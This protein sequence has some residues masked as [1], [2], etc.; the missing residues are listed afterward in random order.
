MDETVE[1]VDVG[2]PKK[3]WK[4]KKK[5]RTASECISRICAIWPEL[6]P[7]GDNLEFRPVALGTSQE[8]HDWVNANLEGRLSH[9]DI[10]RAMSF[11]TSHMVRTKQLRE[12]VVR[13]DLKGQPAGTVSALEVLDSSLSG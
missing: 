1:K 4:K 12:G 8:M 10:S 11:V 9:T 5:K 3:Y 6:W 13:Y 2:A 7:N